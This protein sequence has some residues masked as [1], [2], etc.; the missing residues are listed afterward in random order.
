MKK[1]VIA[2]RGAGFI[3][4]SASIKEVYYS[5]LKAGYPLLEKKWQWEEFV[6]DIRA[7]FLVDGV[8]VGVESMGDP[9]GEMES[10][11]EYFVDYGCEIIVT[12]C[13]TKSDTYRKVTDYL[14]EDN[15]F[16]VL[17]CSHSSY[18]NPRNKNTHDL[19][20]TRYAEHV[21][22]LIESRVNGSI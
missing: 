12:A 11:M 5:M 20:N 6:G 18:P 3:G 19:L 13:R 9:G 15:S 1:L 16:D 7:I 21:V 10:S 17:W 22:W 14:G 2:N 4:K 8:K